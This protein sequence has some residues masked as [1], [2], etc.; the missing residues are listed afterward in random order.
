MNDFLGTLS[1]L[2]VCL[3]KYRFILSPYITERPIGLIKRVLSHLKKSLKCPGKCNPKVAGRNCNFT[4]SDLHLLFTLCIFTLFVNIWH[5]E[6]GG[7]FARNS[8]GIR[9]PIW[10][11]RSPAVP[12]TII[13]V[14]R[15]IT[16]AAGESPLYN[17]IEGNAWFSYADIGFVQL[18]VHA[19][20]AEFMWRLCPSYAQTM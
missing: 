8:G 19:C 15:R 11:I 16:R 13:F 14:G 18:G 10:G 17:T 1:N 12:Q 9:P 3:V 6:F 5:E 4:P 2:S 7:E 20:L